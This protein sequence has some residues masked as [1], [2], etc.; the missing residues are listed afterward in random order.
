MDFK[1]ECEKNPRTPF[2]EEY[3][4]EKLLDYQTETLERR[5]NK[6]NKQY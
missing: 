3:L 5:R 6:F 2:T 1:E 4:V